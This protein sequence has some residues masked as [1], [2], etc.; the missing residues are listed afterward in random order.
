VK[1]LGL[2]CCT[3]YVVQCDCNLA[4]IVERERNEIDFDDEYDPYFE[5]GLISPADS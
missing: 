3:A 5:F 2:N 4:Q 1:N